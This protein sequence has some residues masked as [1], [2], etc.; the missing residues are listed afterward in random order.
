MSVGQTPQASTRTRT[1]WDPIRGTGIVSTASVPVPR[2]TKADMWEG[3]VPTSESPRLRFMTVEPRTSI[4]R[5]RGGFDFAGTASKGGVGE[6][7]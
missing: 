1:S 6:R 5:A 3:T 7:T 4:H 2:Y